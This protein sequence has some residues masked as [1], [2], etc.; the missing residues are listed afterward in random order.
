MSFQAQREI[1]LKLDILITQIGIAGES[2]GEEPT[3]KGNYVF[4]KSTFEKS[5]KHMTYSNSGFTAD[6][7]PRIA[8]A[9]QAHTDKRRTS[10]LHDIVQAEEVCAAGI[11]IGG[12]RPRRL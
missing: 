5:D 2:S 12:R 1:W 9:R 3:T 10:R 6:Q 7:T 11:F 8:T 4:P